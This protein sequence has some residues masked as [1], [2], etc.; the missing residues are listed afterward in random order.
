MR[1]LEGFKNPDVWVAP[2]EILVK[3]S[4][5]VSEHQEFSMV[6]VYS[7]VTTL[8]ASRAGAESSVSRD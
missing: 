4:W 8:A 6:L 1:S 5:V 7:Q 2:Q 3:L